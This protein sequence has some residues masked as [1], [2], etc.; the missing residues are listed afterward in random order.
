MFGLPLTQVQGL[1]IWEEFYHVGD[2]SC[3]PDII[4]SENESL[5]FFSIAKAAKKR[6]P[7]YAYF[8]KPVVFISKGHTLC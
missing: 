5:I 2:H 7:N 3:E 6:I 4:T 1:E 8:Y